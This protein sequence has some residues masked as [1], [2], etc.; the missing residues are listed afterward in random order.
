[1]VS[2]PTLTIH[3]LSG[4]SLT[5]SEKF[6][7]IPNDP[8]AK[9]LVPS[10]CF[11]IQHVI[12]ASSTGPEKT[13]RI[14]LDLGLRRDLT[15]Y[16]EPLQRHC[17]SRQPMSTDPDVVKSLAKGGLTVD[18]ID[19][20]MLSHVHYDHVGMPSDFSNPKT[21]FIIGPGAGDLLSG[22]TTLD[23]GSHSVFEPDLLPA[24]R[25]IELSAPSSGEAS[26]DGQ[27]KWTQYCLFPDTIDFFGD[28][29]LFIVNAPG[30]LPGHINLLAPSAS[31]SGKAV[32]L[33]GDACHD[34][35]LFNGERDIATWTDDT[36]RHCCIHADVP[37][38]LETLAMLRNVAGGEHKEL[39]EVE[40]V[41][42]H[43]WAWEEDAKKEDKFWPGRL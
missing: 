33:A 35:R 15:K 25:T 43:N 32:Y 29:S 16:P 34:I 6:F 27:W 10:L 41:F 39:G 17:A 42:A 36:G 19:Y 26:Y 18:D 11:L 13:T 2:K 21:K 38:A 7:I 3:A 22:K 5:L 8:E 37:R 31:L 40:V 4:G 1:M 12:P 20:V 23:I 14:V 30:H 9:F 24:D 28:G